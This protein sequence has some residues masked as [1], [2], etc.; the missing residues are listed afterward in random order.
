MLLLLFLLL[1]VSVAYSQQKINVILIGLYHFNN[2][3]FDEG[4]V[5]ERSILTKE[6]QDGLEHI[7]NII[8]EKYKPEKVFVEYDYAEHDKLNV[9]YS[10]YKSGAAYYKADTLNDFNKRF[11]AENE[12]F[13]LGFRLAKK[14]GNDSVYAM[15]YDRVPIRFNLLKSK[16]ENNPYFTFPEY[17]ASITA[18]EDF[19]NS[20]LSHEKLEEVLLCLNSDEQYA[21]NKGLY[22]SFLN[23][24]NDSTEFFGSDLVASWYKRNL[25]MYANIQNAIGAADKNI[26]II[27]GAGHAAMMDEFIKN[28]KRFNLVTFAQVLSGAQK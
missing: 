4:K 24:V 19:M 15:D 22:I 13:Q 20:C 5:N 27:A 7:T 17:K 28:D 9:L 1:T 26:V 12:I 21:L 18:M 8:I 6:N 3:G 25:I 10:L 16:L 11:Y 14:A 23:R 2:P